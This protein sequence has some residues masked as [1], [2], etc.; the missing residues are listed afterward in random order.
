M[1]MARYTGS[2]TARDRL[3][4]ALD[5][6][7]AAA[8]FDLVDRLDGTALWYKVGLELY[9]AEG[10]SIVEELRRRG[11]KVFLDLKLHDIPN[12]VSGAVRSV[13]AL[14]AD[15]L[16]LHA[17]GGPV[18]LSAAVEAAHAA[19]AKSGG[20]APRLLAVTVLTSMDA[21]QTS[22]VGV[23][24]SPSEQVWRLGAM[25]MASGVDGLVCSPEETSRFR[26]PE[27]ATGTEKALLVVPGIRP[28]SAAEDD[29]KRTASPGEALRRGASMLVV[30]RP[31]TKAADPALAATEILNEMETSLATSS[32]DR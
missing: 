5:F 23:A 9:L 30:G 25:A 8:A 32:C 7:C 31:I 10:R 21:A 18:M 11:C 27:T 15:L 12:T 28:S 29:Q 17:M 4:I 19:A 14:G 26:D 20:T 22:A 24:A 2:M 3:I 1:S 16:T 13:S 6:P